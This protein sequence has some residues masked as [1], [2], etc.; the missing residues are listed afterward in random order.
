[1]S[2]FAGDARYELNF[3]MQTKLFLNNGVVTSTGAAARDLEIEKAL[4]VTGPITAESE[5]LATAVE[6]LEG[7]KIK[8]AVWAN[9]EPEVPERTVSACVNAYREN[10]CNGII[11]IGGGSSIDTAKMAGCIIGGGGSIREYDLTQERQAPPNLPPLLCIPTT[12]GTGSEVTSMAVFTHGDDSSKR[13]V[14]SANMC[15]NV[16]LVDP[17][18]TYSMPPDLTA[19]TGIDAF[20]HSIEAYLSTLSSPISD[21]LSLYAMELAAKFLPRAVKD[22]EDDEARAGMSVAATMAG[23]AISHAMPHFAHAIGHVLG[24]RC[25]VPHGAACSA[26]LPQG[27]RKLKSAQ[28][29]KFRKI[30]CIFGLAPEDYAGEEAVADAAIDAIENMISTIGLPRL[31]DVM[32]QFEGKP[33]ELVSACVIEPGMMFSPVPLSELDVMDI[34]GIK[35]G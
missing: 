13:V 23:M 25:H 21:S 17:L 24:A 9:V 5:G 14:I 6:T 34:L 26:V 18:L 2:Y 4:I 19:V 31:E 1:M 16:A 12:A 29:G 7:A 33:S 10:E 11:A 15:P 20:C 27:L 28:S 22:G 30:A 8:H 3:V 32:G 35:S